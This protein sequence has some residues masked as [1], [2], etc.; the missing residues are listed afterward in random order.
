MGNQFFNTIANLE[1]KSS[2]FSWQSI[3]HNAAHLKV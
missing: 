1:N 2:K 3:V